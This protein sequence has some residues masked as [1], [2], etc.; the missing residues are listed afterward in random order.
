MRV[1]GFFSLAAFV[2]AGVILADLVHDPAGTTV[3]TNGW[4]T[5]EKAG[6][7]GLLGKTS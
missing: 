7:D 4:T 6:I 2:V 1:T 3:L 5:T